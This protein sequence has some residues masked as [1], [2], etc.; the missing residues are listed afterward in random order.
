MVHKISLP[1]IIITGITALTIAALAAYISVVG[2]ALMFS[3]SALIVALAGGSLEVG[4]LVTTSIVYRYWALFGF[5]MRIYMS[6]AIIG[7]MVVTSGGIYGFLSAAYQKT[8]V[9][10]AQ[11]DSKIELLDQE[12]ARKID[13]LSQ[14]D[15]A[16]NSINSNYITKRME[17]R[18]QLQP[19]RDSLMARVNQIEEE[20]LT[21]TSKKIDTTA[22]I[23]PIMYVA[24]TFD[25]EPKHAANYFIMLLIFIFDPLAI[26]LTIA[27]NMMLMKRAEYKQ[28]NLQNREDGSTSAPP[29]AP[30]MDDEST[31]SSQEDATPSPEHVDDIDEMVKDMKPD[32]QHDDVFD[33]QI[34]TQEVDSSSED[35]KPDHALN[36]AITRKRLRNP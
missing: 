24:E 32:S 16:L 12:Y 13:R 36:R 14:I 10:L 2:L 23:G 5:K 18:E 9:P 25:I 30:N 6:L 26:A 4:K 20:K 21:L 15:N 8:Q 34:D 35:E 1:I 31:D 27:F 3:G 33:T 11:I 29:A 28:Q 7:L 19:E 22:H 17:E